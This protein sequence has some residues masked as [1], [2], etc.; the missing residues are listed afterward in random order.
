MSNAHY[1]RPK[2]RFSDEVYGEISP[3]S[4]SA[5]SG[6]RLL[7]IYGTDGSLMV[8]NPKTMRVLGNLSR[9][10]EDALFAG[11]YNSDDLD[12]RVADREVDDDHECVR[13]RV[14]IVVVTRRDQEHRQSVRL[15]RVSPHQ[16]DLFA[17]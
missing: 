13:Y 1:P 8:Y 5:D 15:C 17:E 16:I 2:T 14:K 10:I 7:L 12:I 3:P 4:L 9:E 6:E 11:G